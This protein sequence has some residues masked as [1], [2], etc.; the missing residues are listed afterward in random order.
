[1]ANLRKD[2]LKLAVLME[3]G[4]EPKKNG[5]IVRDARF[6]CE[7]V[8]RPAG[9]FRCPSACSPKKPSAA[10]HAKPSLL[11]FWIRMFFSCLWQPGELKKGGIFSFRPGQAMGETQTRQTAG[12]RAAGAFD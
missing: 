4:Q 11:T 1:M 6:P 7:T 10:L 8:L 3:V 2:Q 9:N 5:Y 12:K